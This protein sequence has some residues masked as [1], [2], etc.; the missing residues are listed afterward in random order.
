MMKEND[1]LKNKVAI[2]TGASGG[3]GSATAFDF[4][5][6]GASGIIIADIDKEKA[7]KV[8]SSIEKSSSCKCIFVNTNIGK[9]PD[10]RNLF[11][12]AT[13]EFKK[14]DILVNC[15]GICDTFSIDEVNEEQWDRLMAINLRGTYLCCRE[16]FKIMQKQKYGKI[17]NISSISGRIGG[18]VTG[19]DYVTSKGAII[20]MTMSLAK[21]AGLFN[22][23]VNAVAPGFI[24]T[25]MTKNYT[26]F[27][28]E[29]VPLRRIGKPQ[30]VATVITFLASEKSSYITGSTIDVNGGVF[31]S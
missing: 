11:E 1:D 31:M 3:I 9:V 19:I 2:I 7:L 25:E 12:I 8:I 6:N 28:A 4:A 26:H 21:I 27:N 17:I 14:L 23:N 10:I 16:A 5:R 20:A 22:I 30:D 24:D 29:T 18:L 15:A 13:A